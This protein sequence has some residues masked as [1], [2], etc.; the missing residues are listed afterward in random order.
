M[1]LVKVENLSFSYG[2]SENTLENININ[3]DKGDFACIIGENGSGKSTLIKC[4]LGLTPDYTGN[5]SVGEKI[6]YLPQMTEVQNNFPASI[7]EVVLSG[8]IPNNIKNIWY[9]KEDKNTANDI[10]KNLDLYEIRQKCFRELSGGQKQRVLLARAMC[11]T[12]KILILDE[13]T[14]GLDP[15]ITIQIYDTL[16]K[17]NKEKELTVIMISHD[18]NTSLDYCNR[19]IEMKKGKIKFNDTPSKYVKG[20]GMKK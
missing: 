10:M 13:P 4:I 16:K 3:I 12:S 15:N 5:V 18:I 9:S 8:T 19:V 6:G 11:T 14:N 2:G 17:L 1:S 20:G 7:E